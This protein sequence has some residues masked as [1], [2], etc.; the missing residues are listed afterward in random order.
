MVDLS[1]LGMEAIALGEIVRDKMWVISIFLLGLGAILK[2][3][4][5]VSNRLI[6]VILL[7]VAIPATTTWGY[8]SSVYAGGFIR[9][10]DAIVFGGLCHGLAVTSLAVFG[11]DAIYGVWK[12]GVFRKKRPG[13]GGGI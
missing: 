9:W 5:P 7:A 3:L 2:Y 10:F 13:G 6:A 8:L 4:T 11:W 1:F 12:Q